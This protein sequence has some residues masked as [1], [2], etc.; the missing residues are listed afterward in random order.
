[1]LTTDSKTPN[2]P[3][4]LVS[5]ETEKVAPENTVFG[6]RPISCVLVRADPMKLQYQQLDVCVNNDRNYAIV[7]PQQ[8]NTMK[9]V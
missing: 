5:F 7:T 2:T 3:T 6:F 8:H 4:C 9:N 1:M